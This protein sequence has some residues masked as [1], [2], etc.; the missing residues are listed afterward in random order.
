MGSL[1]VKSPPPQKWAF[2]CVDFPWSGVTWCKLGQILVKFCYF[3]LKV[4]K[5]F[6]KIEISRW[7]FKNVGHWVWTVV[8]NEFIWCKICVKGGVGLLTG[9][10]GIG[11][12]MG[13]PPGI[14]IL[15]VIEHKSSLPDYLYIIYVNIFTIIYYFFERDN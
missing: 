12:H 5:I 11:R 4:G 14:H 6:E 7:H 3:E 9:I 13:V 15:A 1:G 8:K 10:Y 2:L